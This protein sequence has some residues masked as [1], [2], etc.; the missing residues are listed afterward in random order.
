MGREEIIN[1]ILEDAQ[2]EAAAIAEEAQKNADEAV[3]AA[4]ARAEQMKAE[5]EAEIA[6]RA[7]RI[8]EGKAAAARLDCAKILLAE[9]RRVLDEIYALA[10]GKLLSLGEH[11]ALELLSRLLREN[12]EA[13]DEVVFTQDCPYAVQAS[14]LSVIAEKK[15]KVSEVREGRGGGFVLRG[16]RCDKDVTFRSILAADREEN[17][18]ALAAQLFK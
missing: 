11:D 16:V 15:L 3:R 2:Q 17:Q 7:L 6:E 14:R 5:T 13:G 9:K 10:L 1:R 12:A 4:E 8:S 18:S